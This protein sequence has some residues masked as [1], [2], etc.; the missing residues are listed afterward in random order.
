MLYTSGDLGGNYPFQDSNLDSVTPSSPDSDIQDSVTGSADYD[1]TTSGTYGYDQ[2]TTGD[3]GS[4]YPIS[5]ESASGVFG[6][7]PTD[8][9]TGISGD[10]PSEPEDPEPWSANTVLEKLAE[11][12]Y[13]QE[14]AYEE[15]ER[16]IVEIKFIRDWLEGNLGELNILIYTDFHGPD[17]EGLN[18]EEQAILRELY[19]VDYNRRA[20]RNALRFINGFKQE[21]IDWF[22]IKEGD[23]TIQRTTHT[24]KEV[25]S[26]N[27]RLAALDA[28]ERMEHLVFNYNLY[29]SKPS[30]VYSTI[31]ETQREVENRNK[32][33]K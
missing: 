11:K 31:D 10:Y 15:G 7:Y 28:Q 33:N 20:Q 23:S 4:Y 26:K 18:L 14:F 8:Y 2:T 30:Q 32:R 5:G 24:H 21:E 9:Q 19:I 27:Y 12:I 16:R 13:D 29:H 17:P 25:A 22:V 6:D 1:Q 3:F